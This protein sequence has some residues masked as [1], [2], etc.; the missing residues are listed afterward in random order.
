MAPIRILAI[1][2]GGIRGLIP[3]MILAEIERRTQRPI[4]SLFDLIA[5][6]STGGILALGLTKPDDEGVAAYSARDL[7]DFYDRDGPLIFNRSIFNRVR[8]A[9]GVREQRYPAGPIEAV[10][11]R[12]FGAAPLSAALTE[13][14]ISSYDIERRIP[15][16]FKRHLART[17][18]THIDYPMRIVA[19]ATSAAPTYFDPLRMRCLGEDDYFA[20][21]DGGVFANNPS[22]CALAEARAI[23]PDR[24]DVFLLS[25]GTGGHTRRYPIEDAEHWGL[26]GWARPILNIALDATNVAVDYQCRQLLPPRHGVQRYLRLQ[27]LLD[28]GNDDMDDAR[29]SNLRILRLVAQ[30][31]IREYD[32]DLDRACATLVTSEPSRTAPPPQPIDAWSS[33]TRSAAMSSGG[34]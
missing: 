26:L 4:A 15:F 22:M 25:L 11:Q 32:E 27:T 21:I 13:V 16:F 8:C 12:Y 29:R 33:S 24:G 18:P 30:R 19:R 14:L 9:G 7:V 5:G 28:V 10:L 31:M 1:D 34:P 23:Y 20:L 6:T 3:A 2:G 17:D